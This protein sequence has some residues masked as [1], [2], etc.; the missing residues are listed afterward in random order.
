MSTIRPITKAL[1]TLE[2]GP[3]VTDPNADRL[4]RVSARA[5]RRL[6]SVNAYF[7]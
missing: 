5:L 1:T 2:D 7:G 4:R 6:M 3:R